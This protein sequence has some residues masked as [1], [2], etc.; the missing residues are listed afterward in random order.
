M[1]NNLMA[2]PPA[3]LFIG[4]SLFIPFI[5]KRYRNIYSIL[6]PIFSFFAISQLPEGSLYS[7]SFLHY[8]LELLR[9]DKISRVFG[10]VFTLCAT[11]SLIYGYYE[12]SI[13]HLSI[14]VYVGSALGVVFSGDIFSLYLFWELMAVFSTFL[15]LN[16]KTK[17]SFNAAKRYILVHIVGGL[18]LLAGIII[19]VSQTGSIGFNLFES[20]NLGT[21]LILIGFLVNAAAIPFHLGYQMHILKQQFLVE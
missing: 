12:K 18:I 17:D 1:I 5:H 4:A 6:I 21:W 2:L 14:L 15:I 8:E 10:F 13:E 7:V 9:V 16:N 11:F 3:L 20:A 19:T